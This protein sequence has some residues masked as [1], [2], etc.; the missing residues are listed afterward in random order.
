MRETHELSL[1][2]PVE[3]GVAEWI[4]HLCGRKLL[5]SSEPE[6]SR[7][8]VVTGNDT[9]QHVAIVDNKRV[10]SVGIK[11]TAALSPDTRWALD[12]GIEWD[13]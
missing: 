13:D 6:F 3:N 12:N 4:C 7:I 2:G 9:V 11:K 8:V 1:N 5:V 10:V